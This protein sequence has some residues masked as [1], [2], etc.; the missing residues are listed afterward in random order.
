MERFVG[1]YSGLVEGRLYLTSQKRTYRPSQ[2]SHDTLRKR[3]VPLHKRN[4][5]RTAYRPL[6]AVTKK[7]LAKYIIS[8]EAISKQA[9]QSHSN[10]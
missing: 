1:K 6:R 3:T 2:K 7:E 8:G 9:K 5:L 4:H 10:V